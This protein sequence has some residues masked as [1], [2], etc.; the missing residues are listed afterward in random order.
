MRMRE[1]KNLCSLHECVANKSSFSMTNYYKKVKNEKILPTNER[2]RD[3]KGH[4]KQRGKKQKK[5]EKIESQS[6]VIFIEPKA[7]PETLNQ[8][9]SWV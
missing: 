9:N 8:L 5:T 1:G 6:E 3:P 2:K 7:A 4:I